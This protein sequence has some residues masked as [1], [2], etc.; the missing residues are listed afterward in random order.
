[1]PRSWSRREPGRWSTRRGGSHASYYG[2]GLWLGW[3]QDGSGLGCDIT[4][5]EQVRIDPEVRLIPDTV[6]DADDPFAWV[7]FAGHWGERE[8][9]VYDGPTGPAFKKQWSAPL[10]WMEGLR[11]DSLRVDAAAVMGPN[12]VRFLLQPRCRMFAAHCSGQ[13][14][15]P[16]YRSPSSPRVSARGRPPL[17]N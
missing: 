10:T 15:S 5:G 6:P 16:A 8:T 12:S 1:M 17:S 14:L 4:S 3:G 2:P 13:A 11:A 7:T 9:W